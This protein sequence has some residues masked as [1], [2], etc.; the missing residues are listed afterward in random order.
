MF[1]PVL[2]DPTAPP[3]ARFSSSGLPAST[4]PRLYHSTA[5][6]LPSGAIAIAGSNPNADVTTTKFGT[7]YR[8][9]VLS[10]PYMT[11]PRPDVGGLPLKADY[12]VVLTLFVTLPRG[13][14]RVQGAACAPSD[15]I[16]G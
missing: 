11:L 7:E 10:P 1:Q 13:A 6:L 2:Y 3:G 15:R 9:E 14:V 5:S 12:G 4:I 16:V 8:L